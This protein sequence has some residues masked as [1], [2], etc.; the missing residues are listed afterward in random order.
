MFLFSIAVS[1][2]QT[3]IRLHWKDTKG[4]KATYSPLNL[5]P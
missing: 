3:D 1:L 2:L 5:D 4:E